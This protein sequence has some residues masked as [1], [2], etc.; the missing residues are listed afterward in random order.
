MPRE[1]LQPDTVR[2]IF[3]LGIAL[4]VWLYDRFHLTSG[5]IVTPAYI[6]L[7]LHHPSA[8]AVTLLTAALAYGAVYVLL[9][10][11]M[12]IT[13]RDRFTILIPMSLALH[14]A[15]TAAFDHLAALSNAGLLLSIGYVI[16]GLI[17]HDLAT[18]GIRNAIGGI[19]VPSLLLAGCAWIVH[20][21]VP[22][23]GLLMSERGAD[24]LF[25]VRWLPLAVVCSVAAS[26]AMSRTRGL[27][28]GGFVGAAYV[29][30]LLAEPTELLMLAGIAMVT[31]LIVTRGLM[32]WMI[33]FGRRKFAAMLLIAALVSWAAAALR[34]TVVGGDPGGFGQRAFAL[35]GLTI[36][37][38]FANDVQRVGLRN[39]LAG[40]AASVLLTTSVTLL[41]VELDGARRVAIAAG[42]G[43][44][45]AM[46]ALTIFGP[47]LLA[48]ARWWRGAG[49]GVLRSAAGVPGAATAPE[50]ARAA[51]SRSCSVDPVTSARRLKLSGFALVCTLV[52][53]GAGAM[54]RDVPFPVGA[55]A[56]AS[57]MI[58]RE[59]EPLRT[60]DPFHALDSNRGT[61][62]GPFGL[63][64]HERGEDA[65]AR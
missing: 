20:G 44:L 6:A 21:V 51:V 19:A 46:S 13:G 56:A 2:F 28:G 29:S 14:L 35:I 1:L 5:S 59:V 53:G 30:M 34:S 38:L 45:A 8:L 65:F 4:S 31:F 39:V 52:L 16:P 61:D 60:A 50:P 42:Y 15:I 55:R 11:F 47:V 48:G 40:T 26:V 23:A 12:I 54:F 49:Q 27:R 22:D 25:D 37:G 7:N 63:T 17:A 18:Q 33:L 24:L 64:Y 57:L 58:P 62:N 41:A 43:G 32:R 36:A 3:V 9:P 10:R